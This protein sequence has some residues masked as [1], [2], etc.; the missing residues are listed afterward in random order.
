MHQQRHHGDAHVGRIAVL[1]LLGADLAEHHGVDDFE[2]RGVRGQR[3]MDLVAVELAVAGSAEVILDVAGAFDRV[4]IGRAALEFMEQRAVRL[5]HHLR[6]H[7]EPAAMRHADH[8]L[9]HAEIAAALD[10]LLQRRDQR[11]AAVE[12]EAL[13]AGEL[14]VAEFLETFGLDQLVEDG[15]PAF[16]GEADLLVR[17]LDAL[18]DPGLLRGVG[19]VHEFDAERLAIGALANRGD[20]AQRAVFEAEHM[21]EEDLAVI[22]GFDEA[23]RARVELLAVLLR[24]D[25]ERIELG[26]EMAAHAVGADQHQRAHGVARCLMQFGGRDVGAALFSS[27]GL[28]LGGELGADGLLDQRP[29][30]VER[31]SQI[32]ARRQRPV[33]AS[34]GSAFGVLLHVSRAVLQ[35]LEELLPLA[36]DRIGVLFVAGIEIVDIGGVGALQKR[37]EGKGGVRV[38]T[39]HDGVLVISCFRAWNT[40]RRPVWLR[41]GRL[42][43]PLPYLWRMFA[44]KRTKSRI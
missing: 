25:A 10:D 35:A 44:P 14:D 2:M 16:A 36:I 8:D 32:I 34:P 1:I 27:L 3:Q 6:Q 18:L 23:V 37:R 11:L 15:A 29:V 9:L 38:L 4:R 24:L 33:I 22:V 41:T 19:D 42:K 17:T 20:L 5:A 40:A 13:G 7:V 26:V 43:R 12:A 30:A 21:I 31:G 28:R 39:R